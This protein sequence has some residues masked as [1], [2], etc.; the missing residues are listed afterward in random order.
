MGATAG[1]AVR[2]TM[3]AFKSRF[4]PLD[5][6]RIQQQ[7]PS[8]AYKAQEK[9]PQ[10]ATRLEEKQVAIG[11]EEKLPQVQDVKPS[12]EDVESWRWILT[13]SKPEEQVVKPNEDAEE[14][15]QWIVSLARPAGCKAIPVTAY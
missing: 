15:S 11:V 13:I 9:P 7:L 2:Q 4:Y 14:D 6:A 1:P 3:P 10:V 12:E 5:P 8:P